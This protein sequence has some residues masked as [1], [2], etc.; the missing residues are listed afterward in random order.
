MPILLLRSIWKARQAPL[1]LAM[2][3]PAAAICWGNISRRCH[4]RRTHFLLVPV[5][6]LGEKFVNGDDPSQLLVRVYVQS[7]ALGIIPNNQRRHSSS[8]S[9]SGVTLAPKYFPDPVLLV[10]G[11]RERPNIGR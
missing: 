4:S 3:K 11:W 7:E 9:E 5:S 2:P 10:D 1:A 6:R 8:E